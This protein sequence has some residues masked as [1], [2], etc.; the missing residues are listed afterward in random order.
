MICRCLC[1]RRIAPA[2][3]ALLTRLGRSAPSLGCTIPAPFVA[4]T[5]PIPLLRCTPMVAQI[6]RTESDDNPRMLPWAALNTWACFD[7][8][9]PAATTAVIYTI[10]AEKGQII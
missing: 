3:L 2:I 5:I 7:T 9:R 1:P 6:C 4:G 8:Q 10:T